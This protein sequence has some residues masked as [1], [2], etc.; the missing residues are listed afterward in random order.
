MSEFKKNVT[1]YIEENIYHNSDTHNIQLLYKA[2][3]YAGMKRVRENWGNLSGKKRACYLSAEFLMGRMIYNNLYNLELLSECEDLLKNN[4]ISPQIFEELEDNALG[5]GGLGR[6]AAC[7][8]DCAATHDIPLD[9]FGIRYKYGIFKQYFTDG[10]QQ[11]CADEWLK[12][13]DPW[14]VRREDEGVV[15]RFGDQTVKAVPYDTPIIGYKGRTINTL[16]LWQSEPINA[17][18]FTAFNNQDYSKAFKERNRA[19]SISAVLYPNDSTDEGKKL[20]LKQQYFFSSASLQYIIREFIR[21]YGCDFSKFDEKYAVQLNDTHPIVSIPEFI[22]IMMEEH[23]M[24]FEKAFELAS[25]VFAYTNHTVMAE[26]MEKWDV[27]LFNEV[28]PAVYPYIVMVNNR[29]FREL[30][31]KGITNIRKYKIID[32]SQIHMARLAI[33]CTHSTNGV[34]EIHT[35]I[36]KNDTIKEWYEL[37]PE[38]FNNK[39][40]GI[41]QRR[42]LALCN[43][44]LSSYITGKIGDGWITDL[45]KLKQLEPFANDSDELKKFSQIKLEKKKQLCEYVKKQ[46]GIVLNPN[47]IFD[48]QIKRLHEYKRQLLNALSILDIYFSI[49]D[50]TIK[51]FYPT[52]FVF[53]AKSAPGYTRAKGIIKLINEIARLIDSDEVISDKIKVI[54]VHN[55][56]VSYAEKLIPAADISEQI[57]TAG[58]EAS[59]TGNMKFMLNGAVTMGTLDG[60]NIEI[61]EQAGEENNYIFGATVEEINNASDSYN[62][63][64]IYNSNPRIKRVMDALIDGTLS[65]GGT[66]IFLELYN[67]ILNGA[68]WHKPDHYYLL[69]DF[70]AYTEARLRANRDYNNRDFFLKKAY[71]NMA[72]AGKFS[73]DR[74]VKEY[75]KEIWKV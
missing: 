26:A 9:G 45:Y 22:R 70:E 10:F 68:S 63:R 23:L 29:L 71:L 6:L 3:S 21:K 52:A 33:Y 14:S 60:A 73:A 19:E 41:T 47:F 59:G 51:K 35:Q 5:N 61:V 2:I 75:A 24:E 40:N 54:F 46:E 72:N 13:S 49:K 65:D 16:K 64:K 38:R 39:T 4:D 28:I 8:L 50:G 44:E 12:Y 67:S 15:I 30:N 55:Y 43:K 32:G 27:K 62:P 31:S 20:R 11:E 42:W 17:F 56:N 36:L 37:Y 69:M 58:T 66:G 34:A 7:F 48:I 25:R 74:T 53:G 18:N 1:Q 57:S